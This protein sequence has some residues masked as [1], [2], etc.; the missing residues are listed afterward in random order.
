M[1]LIGQNETVGDSLEIKEEKPNQKEVT[2]PSNS[3]VTPPK[4]VVAAKST[5]PKPVPVPPNPASSAPFGRQSLKPSRAPSKKIDPAHIPSVA[6]PSATPPPAVAAPPVA[7]DPVAEN[8]PKKVL[9]KKFQF[10]RHL[11]KNCPP[12]VED[13]FMKTYLPPIITTDLWKELVIAD[14]ASSMKFIS[15]L[16]ELFDE[17][18]FTTLS[19]NLVHFRIAVATAAVY[20]EPQ[21]LRRNQVKFGEP[22]IHFR[23][24]VIC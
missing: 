4:T 21:P 1:F 24:G 9:S 13:K 17:V 3:P 23:R 7:M 10:I 6:P 2:K 5:A 15:N 18:G 22:K 12:D 20:T 16:V 14:P 11:A 19:K 8:T